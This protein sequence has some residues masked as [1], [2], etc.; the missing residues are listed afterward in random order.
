MAYKL[1]LAY[2][3]AGFH[4]FQRQPGRRTVQGV[5]EETLCQITGRRAAVAGASRTDAGVHAEGQ[6]A[7]WAPDDC[8]VPAGRLLAALNGRLPQDVRVREVAIV[9]E[10]IDIRHAGSKT[11]SYRIVPGGSTDLWLAAHSWAV[12]D[13]VSLEALDA[14]ARLFLGTHDFY[15]FRGEGSGARTTVR[16]ILAARW[17]ADRGAYVFRVTGT[18]F[19]Y[20]MVRIMVGAMVADAGGRRPGLVREGLLCPR[21]FKAA[22]VAPAHGLTLERI[23]FFGRDSDNDR[24]L[25]T[26]VR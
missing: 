16:T 15:A 21:G 9:P 20:H 5:L 17:H 26:P 7:L 23:D 11:Y 3:G 13:P 2:E 18:G 24:A 8:A 14:R 10:G 22:E 19:L 6:V 4:G 12:S 25:K 1:I